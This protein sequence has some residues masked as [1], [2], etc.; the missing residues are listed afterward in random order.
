[1]FEAILSQSK[2]TAVA[3]SAGQ[4]R[5][6][7]PL[8]FALIS[9]LGMTLLLNGPFLAAVQAKV[10]GQYALQL[11]LMAILFLLN[12][13]L[14]VIFS[15]HR[16]QKPV[17]VALFAIGAFSYYFID[18]FGI[19]VDKSMLQN[20]VETDAAEAMGVLTIGML[21]QVIGVML[22]PL[23]CIGLMKVRTLP[24]KQF[25]R[26]WL[27]ALVLVTLSLFSLVASGYSELAP[28]FRNYREVKHFA[29]PVSPV[30]A[31]V[32]LSSDLVK[33][34]F[35]T[36]F[37]QLGQDAIQPLSVKTEKPRLIVMVLG[38]TARADHFQL[39][40][41]A[42]STN[43]Q[44][45]HLPVYSFTNV[46][47]CGTATAHSVPCMFSNMGRDLYKESQAKN[48]SNVLDILQYAGIDVSWLDNNSGC[49]G[50]C[51]RVPTQ[52]VFEQQK[53]PLCHQGQCLDQV[54]LDA[55][56][57]QLKTPQ[58]SDKLIVLHQLGSHGPEYF[59]RSSAKDKAF[60]PECTDKQLQLCSPSDIVNAY[61]NSIV[62]TDHLLAAVIARLNS[63]KNYQT[64]MF[65]VSDHGES[66]GENGIYLHGLPYWMAP[67]AQTQ[68]PLLW[69]MSEPYASSAKLTPECVASKRQ[70]S[71]SHDN[72][73]HSLLGMFQIK[74]SLYQASKDMFRS[75]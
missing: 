56:E 64:A 9:A 66:L 7:H 46:S 18:S 32:S 15:F 1:M 34:Q 20:A 22:F 53:N 40:G 39:N 68:V 51:D 17:V 63:Q 21:W 37:M 57:Q 24:L 70:D 48:S 30:A 12:L 14:L 75:C 2:S 62:A 8:W 10:P 25:F 52:F 11:N 44:L 26:H 45:S 50:V 27:L 55:L 60:L 4:E 29:L 38:E 61:D 71:F 23:L 49:K 31:A 67:K 41:Y 6:W 33:K 47:S 35:P 69:W 65:Y 73:F 42:R 13:L 36:E 5:L 43:P 58:S 72:V 28:F 16:L 19:V 3:L 59:K 54:L 74:T